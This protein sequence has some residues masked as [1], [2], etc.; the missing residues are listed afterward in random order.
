MWATGTEI[1][2]TSEYPLACL[3]EL[4]GLC[5]VLNRMLI[6]AVYLLSKL[7]LIFNMMVSSQALDL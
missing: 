5:T 4:R 6:A 2:P 7:I 1:R 3:V